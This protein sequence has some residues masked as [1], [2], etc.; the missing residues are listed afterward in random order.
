M[1]AWAAGASA[2][3]FHTFA[4]ST[5][6]FDALRGNGAP[7]GATQM[8]KVV[9]GALMLLALGVPARGA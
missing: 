1:L 5:D 6:E 2:A 9:A 8:M 4:I 3:C 7:A